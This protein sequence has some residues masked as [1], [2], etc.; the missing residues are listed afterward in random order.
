MEDDDPDDLYG[1]QEVAGD[2]ED[3]PSLEVVDLTAE[4][5]VSTDRAEEAPVPEN[6]EPLPVRKPLQE[7]DPLAGHQVSGQRCIHSLGRIKKTAPY[8]LRTGMRRMQD[9]CNPGR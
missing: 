7:I 3:R 9:T 2:S 8:L 1:L 6:V 4:S 5:K